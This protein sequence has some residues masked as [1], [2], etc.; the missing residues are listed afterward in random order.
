MF[1]KGNCYEGSR[2]SNNAWG[3]VVSMADTLEQRTLL[4]EATMTPVVKGWNG[5][6]LKLI[7]EKVEELGS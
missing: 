6:A 7:R 3:L 2:C 4:L 5:K 1:L